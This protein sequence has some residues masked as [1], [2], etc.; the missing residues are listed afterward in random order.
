[1]HQD[2]TVDQARME[3]FME[4]HPHFVR[5]PPILPK[6]TSENVELADEDK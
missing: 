2:G 4:D 5:N 3:H 6:A 1:M